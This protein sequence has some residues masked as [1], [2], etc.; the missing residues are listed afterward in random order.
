MEWP[1][2]PEELLRKRYEAFEKG[3]VDYILETHHSETRDQIEREAVQ[4]WS[5]N[6]RW[7]G[8]EVKEKKT[9]GQDKAF[10][11][12]TVKY[13]RNFETV[14]HTEWAEFRKEDGKWFYYDSEFPAPETIKRASEK[15]GRNDPC[16]CGSGKKFKKC[17]ANPSVA[18]G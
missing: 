7:K 9:E 5:K 10:I 18:S 12:F 17:H 15:L 4:S 13:E 16:H 14:D 2:N 11:H 1:N 6:S 8:L 3:D